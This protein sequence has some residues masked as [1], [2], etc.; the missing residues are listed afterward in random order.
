MFRRGA[1]P[2]GVALPAL[3]PA[4]LGGCL[5]P[6]GGR[7]ELSDGDGDDCK[8]PPLVL[9]C[10]VGGVGRLTF[11]GGTAGLADIAAAISCKVESR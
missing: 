1:A 11:E 2:I 4:E 8:G 5:K 7:F 9:V 3:L 10:I 6:G